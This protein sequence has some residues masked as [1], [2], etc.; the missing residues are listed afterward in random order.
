MD[1]M[2]TCGTTQTVYDLDILVRAHMDVANSAVRRCEFT[3]QSGYQD[4]NFNLE[5]VQEKIL[6]NDCAFRLAIYNGIG[7][8]GSPLV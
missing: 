3:L 1:S 8:I 7:T 6:I 5:I 4:S 2:A